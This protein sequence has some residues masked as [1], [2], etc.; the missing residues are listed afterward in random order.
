M[1][2]GAAGFCVCATWTEFAALGSD[3]EVVKASRL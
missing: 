2:N 1:A 3:S